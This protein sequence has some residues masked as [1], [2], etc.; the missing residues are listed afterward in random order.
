M[1]GWH[2]TSGYLS[3]GDRPS[4]WLVAARRVGTALLLHL[5]AGF[6]NS[7]HWNAPPLLN[8][9]PSTG[10]VVAGKVINH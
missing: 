2:V 6:R 7:A 3:G 4:L 1:F 10:L 9:S 8:M 5:Q